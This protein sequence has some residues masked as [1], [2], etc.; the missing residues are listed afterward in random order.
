MFGDQAKG[1]A[2]T[3]PDKRPNDVGGLLNDTP[4]AS[5]KASPN[6]FGKPQNPKAE[7]RP[8]S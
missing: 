8:E 6:M 7:A 1:S 5:P 4:T 3:M 2:L